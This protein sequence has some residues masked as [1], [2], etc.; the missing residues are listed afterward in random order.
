MVRLPAWA[1]APV[2]TA[3]P[4]VIRLGAVSAAAT[5]TMIALAGQLKARCRAWASTISGRNVNTKP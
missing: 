4:S 1:A 3:M 5:S 2:P